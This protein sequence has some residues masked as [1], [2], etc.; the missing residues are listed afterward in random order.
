MKPNINRKTEP[1]K[2]DPKPAV[3]TEKEQPQER[4]MSKRLITL[5]PKLPERVSSKPH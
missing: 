2:K 4:R 1:P 3:Q 5:K